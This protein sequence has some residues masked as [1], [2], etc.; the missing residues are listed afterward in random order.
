V[1][2]GVRA[3]LLAGRT[4]THDM[5]T[6][7]G[8]TEA[9]TIYGVDAIV[10][11]RLLELFAA[12]WPASEPVEIVVESSDDALLHPHDVPIDDVRWTCIVDPID[13]SRGLMYDKRAAWSLAAVAPR[14]G[15]R[16]RLRD[17][18]AAAMTELPTTKQ[19][20]SDQISGVRGC[21][22]AGLVAER[23]D[24]RTSA[25]APISVEPSN[26]T[27]FEHGFASFAKFFPPGR[28]QIAVCEDRFWRALH[29]D[30]RVADLAVFD[31]QY[32]ATA[33]Q[34]HELLAGHDRM[35]GDLRPLA[36]A[37]AGIE[38]AFVCH[39]YDCC[40]AMLLEE[41]GCV[42]TTPWGNALDAPLDITTPVAWIAF[43][44]PALARMA[45]PAL[46]A[47]VRDTFPSITSEEEPDVGREVH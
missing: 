37:E 36:F 16:P 1:Q 5:A 35:V 9:D 18:V 31:D 46:H 19:W 42:V 8:K 10:D 44:N 25:R 14:R 6:V 2:D 32:L 17:V 22:R 21:G 12:H 7:E 39:P 29:G 34:F 26:A 43:A 20:A 4:T 40:T 45:A 15:T 13:G 47:A 28:L 38:S 3:T 30:E 27:G 33:G 41:A 24:V 11:T 23:T